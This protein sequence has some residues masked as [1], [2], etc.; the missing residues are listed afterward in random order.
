MAMAKNT[1][2][3]FICRKFK[4]IT[5]L[6]KG[7]PKEFCKKDFPEHQQ[8]LNDQLHFIINDFDQFKQN[9]KENQINS[10]F[11]EQINQWE[12]NSIRLSKQTAENCRK[13]VFDY[14]E[15][16]SNEI[17]EKFQRLSEEIKEMQREED[18]NEFDL[19]NLKEKLNKINQAFYDQSNIFIKENNQGFIKEISIIST[20]N[21][22]NSL[23]IDS[24]NNLTRQI[25]MNQQKKK[26]FRQFG[27]IVAEGNQSYQ[28]YHPHGIFVDQNKNIF[29]ADWVNHHIIEWRSN[30]TQGEIIAGGY[31]RGNRLDKLDRPT[32]MI[33]DD[34]NHSIII[35][36]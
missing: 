24:F 17:E 34:Q 22:S 19:E 21:N 35:A 9:I 20:I 2:Q 3:C 18:F 5:F 23:S 12:Q 28:I 10:S 15:K 4:R 8:Q 36:D 7:C 14:S 16:H 27:R 26:K 1:T 25:S 11:I 29:I 13:E 32:D 31:G 33:V 30:E 6:C